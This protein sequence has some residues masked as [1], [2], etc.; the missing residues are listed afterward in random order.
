[1][2]QRIRMLTKLIQ[3]HFS[4]HHLHRVFWELKTTSPNVW[5]H[6]QWSCDTLT[7]QFRKWIYPQCDSSRNVT[8]IRPI[9][10]VQLYN[11]NCLDRVTN[12][13]V[14]CVPLCFRRLLRKKRSM[15][16]D[17]KTEDPD[18]WTSPSS[19]YLLPY[20]HVCAEVYEHE[21]V[22]CAWEWAL[23]TDAK[24]CACVLRAT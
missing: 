16:R 18:E 13:R 7:A 2:L 24:L 4:S 5:L 11:A 8:N 12:R 19:F 14:C 22:A 1:M 9:A 6:H 20:Q 3:N 23:K 10:S 21:C 17:A 15:T